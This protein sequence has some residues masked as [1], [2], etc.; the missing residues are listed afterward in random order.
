[1]LRSVDPKWFEVRKRELKRVVSVPKIEEGLAAESPK[2]V[3]VLSVVRDLDG[4]EGADY[5]VVA[6]KVGEDKIIHLLAVGELFETKPGRLKVL[7]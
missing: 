2:E 3:D 7:E 1:M 6:S 5:D 4:G